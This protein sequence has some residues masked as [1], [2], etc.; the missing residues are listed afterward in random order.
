[1]GRL[2][3]KV[4]IEDR[5]GASR[6]VADLKVAGYF[7]PKQTVGGGGAIWQEENSNG[8]LEKELIAAMKQA[9]L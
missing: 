5:N 3:F 7:R 6:V 9:K 4:T 2:T 1:M 8:T